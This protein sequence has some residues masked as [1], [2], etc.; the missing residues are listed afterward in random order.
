MVSTPGERVASKGDT[1]E[2]WGRSP[3][4]APAPATGGHLPPEIDATGPLFDPLTSPIPA[5]TDT[6]DAWKRTEPPRPQAPP[7]GER[8]PQPPVRRP[9]P[10]KM[11]QRTARPRG[12]GGLRRVKRTLRHVDPMSV[13]KVSLIYFACLLV[14]WLIVVAIIYTVLNGAGL[15]DSIEKI[16]VK[17]LVLVDKGFEITLGLVEKWAFFIGVLLTVTASLINVFLAF[18]Y[19]AIS[20]AVGGVQMTFVER[21][22]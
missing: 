14:L 11:P 16:V 1:P 12:R 10:D 8:R 15:F 4:P 18:L 9:P 2:V 6:G 13:F 5:E 17:D 19:N 20:D 22:V 7:T 3:E 21:D